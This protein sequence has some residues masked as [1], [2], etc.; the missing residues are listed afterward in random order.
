[1]TLRWHIS[2]IFDH[3]GWRGFYVGL[4][5]TV[6]RAM[7]L[8]ATQLSTYDHTKHHLINHGYMV[9]GKQCHFVSSFIAGVAVALVT[10]PADVIKTRVMNVDPKNPAYSGVL[11]CIQK[12]VKIEGARGLYKGVNA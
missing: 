7:L 3:W 12:I 10:S 9:E 8:N 6:V 4:K 11:D 2:H 1:M 5:P